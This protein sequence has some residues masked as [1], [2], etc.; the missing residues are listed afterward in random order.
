MPIDPDHPQERIKF[1]LCDSNTGVMLTD[2]ESRQIEICN[3]DIDILDLSDEVIDKQSETN[4]P[5]VNSAGSLAYIIYT[6]G[7]TGSPK[8]V[9]ITHEN[10]VRLM[11][12]DRFLFD[13]HSED[14]WTMFHAYNFDFSV[15]EMY[16]ALLYGGKLVV[17]PKM[18][19]K[20]PKLYLEILE[21]KNVTIL[22]QT[23]SAFYNLIEEE[24]KNRSRQLSLRYV[25]F[26]G[27]ALHPVKLK[28]WKEKYPGT[29]L[30]NMFG[31]TETTVH[32]TYKEIDRAEIA[33]GISNIGKPLPTLT[34]YIS[35]KD[36]DM[37]PIGVSGELIV[38]GKGLARGYLNQPELTA[39]KF[40]PHPYQGRG[41]VYRSGDLARF[42]ENGEM[43]YLGRIDRQV[44]VRG[45]RIELGEIENRLLKHEKI[46]S[47]VVL[48]NEINQDKYLCAYI[49]SKEDLKIPD[50]KEYLAV[51][52]PDYMFPSQFIKIDK[53]PV[54]PN[55]KID[56]KKLLSYDTRLST[57][58]EYTPP[59]SKIE[60]IMAEI[61]KE[62][63]NLDKVSIQDNIFDLGGDSLKIIKINSR[64]KDILKEDIPV[65]VLFRYSTIRSLADYITRYKVEA[66]NK[67][68][69]TGVEKL[70]QVEE[71]MKDTIQ[72][73]DEVEGY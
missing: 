60:K 31:I 47:A 67:M 20:D 64:I 55:G 54:T 40:V 16:G 2:R 28:E 36:L 73:F 62:V 35:N 70:D 61:W 45:F 53:I 68:K 13:F 14:V 5:Q 26:G 18:I 44:Q 69:T 17:I 15:W 11:S 48:S 24:L 27:E 39:E 38:G 43:E 34:A 23:P 51:G 8:G 29:R 66:I 25:I 33:S 4:L 21:N 71:T 6:S 19:A 56:K 10:V 37:L 3:E 52:L 41:R 65:L 12:N 9:L 49:I 7:T 30:I 59:K 46:E 72:L 63:L 1:I 58:E 42:L 32:V 22:N 50:L 57:G